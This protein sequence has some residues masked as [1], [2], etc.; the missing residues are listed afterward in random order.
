LETDAKDLPSGKFETVRVQI[1]P[2]AYAFRTGDKI[3][4]TIQAP[5]GDR[6]RWTFQTIENGTIQ[7]T[8]Q[9]GTS[10]LVLPVIPGGKA[11]SAPPPCPSNRGQPC[12]L[13]VAATNGG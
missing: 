6:P 10:K 1:Y 3:R 11:G 4:V 8:I 12:R 9:L 13:Y 7:N 2:V 5:G